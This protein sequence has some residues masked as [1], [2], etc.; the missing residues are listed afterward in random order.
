VIQ[1]PAAAREISRETDMKKIILA[2]MLA[3][4]ATVPSARAETAQ[5]P[6]AVEAK[7]GA[8]AVP[9]VIA[10]PGGTASVRVKDTPQVR[11]GVRLINL[12]DFDLNGD[13]M[14]A[15]AEI[16]AT[17][18]K[19]YDT[20]GND[21]IDNIEYERSSMLTVVPFDKETTYSYD[22]DGDGT[23]DEK[24]VTRSKFIEDTMLSRF[25]AN[26]N[27]LSPLEFSGRQFTEADIDNDRFVNAREWH[28]SYIASI[29]AYNK[30]RP[31]LNK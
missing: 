16:G 22:F 11:T 18:F 8:T 10:P 27:G 29:D 21:L 1:G 15:Q 17:L 2:G 13:K 28:G 30:S 14:L 6:T 12:A 7:E 23:V 31:V 5:T 9:E 24:T 19:L 20:D 26:A 4:L 25:D 3:A